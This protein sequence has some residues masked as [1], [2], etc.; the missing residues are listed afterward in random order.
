MGSMAMAGMGGMNP[1]GG[2]LDERTMM[3]TP[4]EWTIEGNIFPGQG[5]RMQ[6]L[7]QGLQMQMAGVKLFFRSPCA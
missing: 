3:M 4:L 6:Q 1:M 2:A 5:V 7:N